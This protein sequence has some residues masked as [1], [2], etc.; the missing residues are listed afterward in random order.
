MLRPAFLA[1]SLLLFSSNGPDQ[2]VS[3]ESQ[4]LQSLLL[5]IRQL[6]QD[7]QTAAFAARR[8]QM[9]IFRLNQQEGVVA[10]ASERLEEARRER[11]QMEARRKYCAIQIKRYEEMRDRSADVMEHKRFE[12]AILDLKLQIEASS[13]EEQELQVKETQLGEEL[14]IEESKLAQLQDELD[15]LTKR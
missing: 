6:R 5:E 11:V 15:R 14:R 7:V 4:T 10:R 9:L 1:F 3:T 2:S 12:D 8:A 13:S